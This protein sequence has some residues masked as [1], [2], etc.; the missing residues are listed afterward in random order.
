MKQIKI[1][2]VGSHSTETWFRNKNK[3]RVLVWVWT[4]TINNISSQHTFY[5]FTI[6]IIGYKCS[7][8]CYCF[9]GDEF[10]LRKNVFREKMVKYGIEKKDF[11]I[12]FLNH[13]ENIKPRK[14]T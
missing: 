4:G 3:S 9:S 5:K 13:W 7:S 10:E 12:A 2:R 1:R 8:K 11:D 6:S 14:T